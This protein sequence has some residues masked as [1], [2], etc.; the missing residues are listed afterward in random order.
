MIKRINQHLLTHYPLIW[1]TRIIWVLAA[2]ILLH[3]LFF[4]S[5]FA[6]ISSV[7]FTRFS[8]V[9]D[10]GGVS[11]FT[12][13]I[14]CSLLVLIIWLIYYLRNNAFKNHYRIDKWYLLKEFLIILIIVISSISFFNSYNEGV[15]LK[16]RTITPMAEFRK[17]LNIANHAM[18]YIP[19][20]KNDYFILNDCEYKK[21]PKER[22]FFS[23]TDTIETSLNPNAHL[24][25]EALKR[26]DAFSYKNY[27][28][29][30][31]NSYDYANNDSAEQIARI[32]NN[33][34]DYNRKDS[35][36]QVIV[37]FLEICKK[38]NVEHRL[39]VDQLVNNIFLTPQYNVL[40]LVPSEKYFTSSYTGNRTV[41]DY[42]FLI[43]DLYGAFSFADEGLPN[44][45]SFTEQRNVWT[46]IAYVTIFLTL[47]VL[48]YRRFSK[49][50]FLIG[51]VGSLIWAILIGLI[52][53]GTRGE[54]NTFASICIFLCIAFLLVGLVNLN[55]GRGKTIAGTT[56][57]WHIFLLPFQ[58]LLLLQI[59]E[60]AFDKVKFKYYEYP[61]EMIKNDHPILYWIH[62]HNTEIIITNIFLVLLYIGLVFNRWTKKWQSMAEE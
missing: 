59:F 24:V 42:Y 48:C 32:R 61:I 37:S 45:S 39:D 22:G 21:L 4:L 13:S 16:I 54:E 33:W 29:L 60:N 26:P 27:C 56:L 11:M 10:V 7:D 31:N 36:R 38:Y 46:A 2:N 44:N 15:R 28:D 5:G 3:L 51:L 50:V 8:K 47:I 19:Q 25:K 43:Y 35:I 9:E 55:S 18:A 62:T 41:N 23:Y 17:E 57:S 20:N 58:I 6:T 52:M 40:S 1:N 12:F 14:L 34:I 30:A 53:A 49:R